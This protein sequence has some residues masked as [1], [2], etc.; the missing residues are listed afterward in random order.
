MVLLLLLLQRR[1]LNVIELLLGLILTLL[2]QYLLLTQLE[3]LLIE[4]LLLVGG[5][6]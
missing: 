1:I 6:G 4:L 3:G 2:R 5:L